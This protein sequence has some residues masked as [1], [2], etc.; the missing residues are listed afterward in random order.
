M[1]ASMKGFRMVETIG[2]TLNSEE[3]AC[4]CDVYFDEGDDKL[5]YVICW[6]NRS[7]PTRVKLRSTGLW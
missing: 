1:R 5:R 4:T 2:G 3:A 6:T 7:H